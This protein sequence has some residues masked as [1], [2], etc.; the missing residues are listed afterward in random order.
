M[1]NTEPHLHNSFAICF[2]ENTFNHKIGKSLSAVD[3]SSY[4]IFSS[5]SFM[6]ILNIKSADFCCC[7]LMTVM[8]S[9]IIKLKE[10][11]IA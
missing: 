6:I 7:Q 3:E 1:S 2:Q 11:K 5:F 8:K 9:A 10:L 4:T